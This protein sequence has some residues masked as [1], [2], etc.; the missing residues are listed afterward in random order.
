[1]LVVVAAMGAGLTL[2]APAE[3]ALRW[4][5]CLEDE[6]QCAR[7]V[8]PLDRSG[9]VSG[10]VSLSV[11][12]YR[13]VPR[14]PTGVTLLLAGEP[15][16]PATP[17]LGAGEY[18]AGGSLTTLPVPPGNDLVAFDQR[19]TG[20]SGV[21][22]CRDLEAATATDAGRE[23][24]A[25][26]ALLG[27]RRALYGTRATVEDIE[28]LRVELGVPRLTI[29]GTAYGSYVAQRYALAHPDRV[30]R[31]VLDLPVDA[32]GID[33][34]RLE[35]FAAARRFLPLVC[36][37][38]CGGFTRDPVA[39][40]ARLG[41]RLAR[42][43]LRGYVVGA[44]GRRR[45]AR[46]TSQD[47]LYTLGF[48]DAFT[49][50]LMDYPAAVVSALRGDPA[51][52][53]RLK[54]RAV[55]TD[56][57]RPVTLSSPATRAAVV[58][59]E[60]RF[61]WA[62][63]ATP[64][65]RD[66]AATATAALLTGELAS[67]FGAAA[68]IRTDIVR[69]CRRWPT[70]SAAPP[71]E[72]GP[73]PDIPVLILSADTHLRAPVETARR[74]AAR[75]PQA[76]LVVTWSWFGS[77]LEEDESGCAERALERFMAGRSVST[78]CPRFRPLLPPG[79]PPPTRLAQLRPVPGVPGKRG[80]VLRAV[81]LTFGDWFDDYYFKGGLD[82]GELERE[83]I[84]G[85]GL[86]RGRYVVGENVVRIERLEFVPGV[87]ISLRADDDAERFPLRVEGPGRLDGRLAFRESDDENFVIPVE[88]RVG[89]RRV[90]ARLRIRSRIVELV[91]DEGAAAAL[92]LRPR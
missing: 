65:E 35:S 54:R 57:G 81:G 33:A 49:V 36:R 44:D 79:R 64:A 24:A 52:M 76:A 17:L 12:R 80:R 18:S 74:I 71:E 10:S 14:K 66:A 78:R 38:G 69:L 41:E 60:A 27:E 47:L 1:M 77:L 32:A 19:G 88:G 82:P 67:P 59:E 51:P 56:K 2:A 34:L 63:H 21:L 43:P 90:R 28:A 58:C 72:P 30:E 42:E 8:V 6:A 16:E 91:A 23:A 61:P 53:F 29:V 11:V 84:R 4:R 7:L 48:G 75:F 83:R 89:G 55:L 15:G 70:A 45:A 37:V 62:W 3:G 26:A 39:D 86:R 92:P 73:M 5:P 87:Q 13:D 46:L 40:T 22:R 20:A 31:L 9:V 85:T 50:S 68:A 25:C